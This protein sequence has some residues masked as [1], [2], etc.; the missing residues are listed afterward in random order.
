MANY[1][2][3][4]AR[5]ATREEIAKFEAELRTFLYRAPNPNARTEAERRGWGFD[6]Y[7]APPEDCYEFVVAHVKR[8]M[9]LRLTDKLPPEVRYS[10]LT[11]LMALFDWLT[12]P[13]GTRWLLALYGIAIIPPHPGYAY[14]YE[15]QRLVEPEFGLR[16]YRIDRIAQEVRTL[17]PPEEFYGGELVDKLKALLEARR[18]P[19]VPTPCLH[20]SDGM[21]K[22]IATW[23]RNWL[24]EPKADLH[25]P[26][27][28][29]DRF[30]GYT[31]A[32]GLMRPGSQTER[33]WN[34]IGF[35]EDIR[36]GRLYRIQ[37]PAWE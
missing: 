28:K 17:L 7:F 6:P 20:P 19:T 29:P 2:Y 3:D 15:N 36:D 13:D 27:T 33:V 11:C 22:F 4:Q 5:A 9:G 21:W 31:W 18:N 1:A 14:F 35:A 16:I 34:V 25:W 12:T 37:R 30:S 32:K 26:T 8:Q 10:A 23:L 24:V